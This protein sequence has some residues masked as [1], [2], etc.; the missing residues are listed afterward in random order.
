M[1]W[2]GA[3]RRRQFAEA[4]RER[5]GDRLADAD[6]FVFN[7]DVRFAWL[8]SR[9]PD[10]ATAPTDVLQKVAEREAA[11]HSVLRPHVAEHG[12]NAAIWARLPIRGEGS[13]IVD[14]VVRLDVTDESVR[15]AERMKLARAE[16]EID[17][18]ERRRVQERIE[19]LREYVLRDPVA[20]K[21]Y[22]LLDT[23][24]ASGTANAK[25]ELIGLVQEIADWNPNGRW[26][27][28]SEVV[29]EFVKGR[30]PADLDNAL[31]DFCHLMELHQ[32][33]D[34]AN[35][36]RRLGEAPGALDA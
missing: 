12:L 27:R 1:L 34:L 36:L 29:L 3:S 5:F 22:L 24:L 31:R 17:R 30:P 15:A 6:G 21:L 19:F 20:A 13:E 16:L 25:E 9:R 32:E 33:T 35:R 23:N 26:L 11:C 18:I 4:H 8:A 28:I 2:M 14:A 10:A 7:A